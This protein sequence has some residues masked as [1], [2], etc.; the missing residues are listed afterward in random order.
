MTVK[1]NDQ[2]VL[3]MGNISLK[4]IAASYGT[5]TIVYDEEQI[6]SQCRRFHEAFSNSGL[7]YNISYASKAFSSFQ[8]FKLIAEDKMVFDVV[9]VIELITTYF[10]DFILR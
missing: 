9:I 7:K 4:T 5:P 3:T 2:G 8:L 6:R 10:I 1:Y